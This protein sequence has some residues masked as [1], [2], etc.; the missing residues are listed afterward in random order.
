MSSTSDNVKTRSGATNTDRPVIAPAGAIRYG[1]EPSAHGSLP[2]DG[3]NFN[4]KS[5]GSSLWLL[6]AVAVVGGMLLFGKKTIKYTKSPKI[7]TKKTKK[8]AP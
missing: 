5:T 7:A 4:V 1:A 2:L 8:A 3:S 6:A